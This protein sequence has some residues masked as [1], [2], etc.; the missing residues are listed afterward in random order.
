MAMMYGYFAVRV[1][2]GQALQTSFTNY[3]AS[4]TSHLLPSRK[5][6]VVWECQWTPTTST[7]WGRTSQYIVFTHVPVRCYLAGES[8]SS[9]TTYKYWHCST[10]RHKV[11]FIYFMLLMVSYNKSYDK[12]NI[13]SIWLTHSFSDK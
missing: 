8:S 10:Q 6:D 9:R 3:L 13:L 7:C 4:F 12:S 11:M 5:S 2:K 1:S